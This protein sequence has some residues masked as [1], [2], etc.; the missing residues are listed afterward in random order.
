M[1]GPATPPACRVRCLAAIR[2]LLLVAALGVLASCATPR[3]A[4]TPEVR[5]LARL[6]SAGDLAGADALI[7]AHPGAL[8]AGRALD[9]A[10]RDGDVDAARHFLPRAGA[11]AALDPD[12]T[13]PLIRAV[14]DAPPGR[15]LALVAMLMQGG[16]DP[17]RADRYDRDAR[18]HA[19]MRNQAELLALLDGRSAADVGLGATLAAWLGAPDGTPPVSPSRAAPVLTRERLLSGSPWRPG[20]VGAIPADRVAVRFHGDGTAD[21]LRLRAGLLQPEPMPRAGAAW[22]LERGRLLLSIVGEPFAAV[23]V[24]AGTGGTVSL[25]CAPRAAPRPLDA[26]HAI[27]VATALLSDPDEPPPPPSLLAIAMGRAALPGPAID[28]AAAVGAVPRL[29]YRPEAPRVATS[30]RAAPQDGAC[31][32]GRTRPRV[33]APAAAGFGDW[34]AL[35]TA[36]FAASAPLSGLMCTQAQARLAALQEC[37]SEGGRS[38]RCRSVGG[39]PVG[40]VSALAGLPGVD[41]GWI[42]CGSTF[43]E[44]RS[45]ARA[46]CRTDL[47]CDCQIVAVSGANVGA[48]AGGAQC[49][50]PARLSAA[51][52]SPHP[53]PS[54]RE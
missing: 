1:Y 47:G 26:L 4:D 14:R 18:D 8:D 35:D 15:R 10:L 46:A 45:R 20:P 50:R 43:S 5:S 25:S 34:Y 24:G 33:P 22:Q 9:L 16:A 11:D 53:G 51:T 17:A 39:C 29:A 6:L 37:R 3:P 49:T 48:S 13:T 41:A 40:Q 36:R 52:G 12:A 30:L 54:S 42:A 21:V 23:C 31:S 44:A 2:R 28:V 7:A 27:D 19:A 32:P 38:A